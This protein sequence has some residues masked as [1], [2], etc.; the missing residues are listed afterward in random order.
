VIVF[1][2]DVER[3][4]AQLRREIDQILLAHALEIDRRGPCR[5]RLGFRG[6]FAGNVGGWNRTVLDRPDRLAGDA[7]ED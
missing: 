2:D 6:P 5:E 4:P 7:I 3:L 1:R